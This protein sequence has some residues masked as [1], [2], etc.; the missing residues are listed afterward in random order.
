MDVQAVADGPGPANSSGRWAWA[1]LLLAAGVLLA[2][3]PIYRARSTTQIR[4]SVVTV[5]TRAAANRECSVGVGQCDVAAVPAAALDAVTRPFPGSVVVESYD[6]SASGRVATRVVQIRSANGVVVS[7]QSRC[8]FRG[9]AVPD[10]AYGTLRGVGPA[11]GV[12]VAGGRRGCSTAVTMTVPTAV[13]V[14]VT[15]A[16]QIAND[17]AVALRP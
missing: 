15:Q 14:P 11:R 2:C 3:V 7:V 5:S 13:A 4:V 8:I 10:R 6:L 17:P 16:R 9:P 1:V 12:I